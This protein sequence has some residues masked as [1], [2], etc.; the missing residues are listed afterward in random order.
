[1]CI[2]QSIV[3]GLANVSGVGLQVARASQADS[4]SLL[5]LIR[6]DL[7]LQALP[8]SSGSWAFSVAARFPPQIAPTLLVV[9]GY[10]SFGQPCAPR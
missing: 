9:R 6:R 7:L 4:A 3:N 2:A 8:G 5:R 1:V 10:L